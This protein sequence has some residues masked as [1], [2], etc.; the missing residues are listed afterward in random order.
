M[1]IFALRDIAN[2]AAGTL[3]Y[4]E[5]YAR[6]QSFY[7]ELPPN[8]DPWDLPFILHEFAQRGQRTVSDAWSRCWVESRIVPR[9]R[10]NLGGILRENGLDDYDELRLL[11]LSAGMCAQ[12]GCYLEPV[13]R[14][15]LPEWYLDRERERLADVFALDG[16]RLMAVFRTGEARI[17]PAREL[18]EGRRAYDRVLSDAET[19][20]H[21]RPLAGGHGA[22][23]GSGLAVSADELRDAGTPLPLD[24]EDIGR[25]VQQS[26]CDTAEAAELLGCTRQNISDLVRRGKL[27]PLQSSGHNSLFL[28][29]DILGRC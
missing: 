6:P 11:E 1:K 28:R 14:E 25:L 18:L 9:E 10:Q 2:E 17:C 5:C 13:S 26:V 12:D 29:S 3:A 19:F 20:S 16:F 22:G 27:T 24:A 8:A 23:W 15:Q 7:F 21:M 4:L